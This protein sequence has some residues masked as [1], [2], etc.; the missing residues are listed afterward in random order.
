M[1][2]NEAEDLARVHIAAS[3][4]AA[5]HDLVI[6]SSRT[7]EE[8]FGWVFFYNTRRFVET[9]AIEWALAGNAPLI[10]DRATGEVI[11]TGTARPIEQHIEYYREHRSLNG[12]R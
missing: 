8:P 1:T 3:P 4:V 6:D 7:R 11:P 5:R 10:V 2:R 9:G 12:F